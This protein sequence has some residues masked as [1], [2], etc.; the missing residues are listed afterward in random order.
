YERQS[1]ALVPVNA[2]CSECLRFQQL[3]S[4]P[5]RT[6]RRVAQPQSPGR[7]P[8]NRPAFG[9]NEHAFQSPPRIEHD[10]EDELPIRRFRVDAAVAGQYLAETVKRV[11]LHTGIMAVLFVLRIEPSI[12]VRGI[13]PTG[14]CVDYTRPWV[15]DEL[16]EAVLVRVMVI[17]ED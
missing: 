17:E 6:R 15:G 1:A 7:G 16:D 11:P 14:G 3:F 8:A 4:L 13:P 12:E 2:G 5:H 10:V 9:I